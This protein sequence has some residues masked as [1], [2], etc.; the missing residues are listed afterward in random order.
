MSKAAGILSIQTQRGT[1]YIDGFNCD[2]IEEH[3]ARGDG[4]RWFYDIRLSTTILRIFDPLEV[5]F[6]KEDVG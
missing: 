4:D 2:H 1:T 5:E 3:P 6:A